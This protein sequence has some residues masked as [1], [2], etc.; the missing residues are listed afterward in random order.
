[1]KKYIK[2]G[3]GYT[4]YKGVTI[5]DDGNFYIY[6][7]PH[8]K[9]RVDFSNMQ[10]VRDHI[11]SQIQST[12]PRP[13]FKY[14]VDY[15]NSVHDYAYTYVEAHSKDE[16]KKIAQKVLGNEIWRIDDVVEVKYGKVNL[17]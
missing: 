7:E 4:T 3:K 8:G 9:G 14:R 12:E 2:C 5:Y 13:K 17:L 15:Y 1:M 16:A 10:E 6:T 11:D